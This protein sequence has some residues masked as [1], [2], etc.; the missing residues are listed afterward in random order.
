M[1][2]EEIATEKAPPAIG[3]YSQALRAGDLVFVS[4]AIPLDPDSKE[5]ITGGIEA[6]TERVLKNLEAVLHEAGFGLA[7]VVKTTVYLADISLFEGM[8][9]VYGEFFSPP[10]PARATV[11][12]ARLPKGVGVEI[13]AIAVN[14]EVE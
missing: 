1:K 3:P 13:D 8:N 2:I 12:V 14:R 5:V 11:E 9:K 10:Y 7:N 6:Q 4:G